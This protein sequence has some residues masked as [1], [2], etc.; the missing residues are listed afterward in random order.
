MLDTA[1][2]S[3]EQL[4]EVLNDLE[5]YIYEIKNIDKFSSEYREGLFEYEYY[6]TSNNNSSESEKVIDLEM[7]IEVFKANVLDEYQ[8]FNID[9]QTKK[10]LDRW[11]K[12]N[13]FLRFKDNFEFIESHPRKMINEFLCYMRESTISTVKNFFRDIENT[14]SSENVYCFSQIG[15]SSE[16]KIRLRDYSVIA[17]SHYL[18]P[19]THLIMKEDIS[20]IKSCIER[21]SKKQRIALIN[22]RIKDKN[23][24]DIAD[25]L[26]ISQ[27][28]VSKLVNKAEDNLWEMLKKEYNHNAL[29]QYKKS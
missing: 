11:V 14:I 8:K 16:N 29:K 28:A 25:N 18:P 21:L 12:E 20:L 19:E 24:E 13:L 7:Y 3:L 9:S 17:A 2:L 4:N 15:C 27:Q 5:K 23:Q 1:E 10:F 26:N 6:I 22:N